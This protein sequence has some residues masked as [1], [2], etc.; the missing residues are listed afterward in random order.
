[1]KIDISSKFPSKTD[2]PFPI[3]KR[4]KDKMAAEEEKEKRRRQHVTQNWNFFFIVK[5]K[6]LLIKFNI[7]EPYYCCDM[8]MK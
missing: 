4:N 8:F 2:S 6:R 7:L 1:M 3:R 5:L